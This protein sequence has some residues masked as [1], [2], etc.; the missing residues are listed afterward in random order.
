MQHLKLIIPGL[1][2]ALLCNSCL[3]DLDDDLIGNC[4]NGNG[5]VISEELFVSPFDGIELQ[6]SASV[7]IRQ[8]PTQRITVEGSSD[9][10][11]RLDLRV[12]NG[13]LFIDLDRCIRNLRDLRFFIT[14]PSI[15]YLSIAGSGEIVSE[16]FLLVDDIELFISGSGDMD[17]GLEADE[18]FA[19]ISGAGTILLE[20]VANDTDLE[21]SGSGDYLTFGLET[22]TSSVRIRGSGSAEVLVRE[23]LFVNISGSGDVLYRGLP[24][25]DVNISGSGAVIN[26]N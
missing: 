4:I 23:A 10:I 16:N 2:L 1:L 11:D 15:T 20:G 12:R 13:I 5:P 19:S 24:I 9:V 17:L 26:A 6:L 18:V 25:L 3:I 22:L 21:I 14:I 8:G 7:S